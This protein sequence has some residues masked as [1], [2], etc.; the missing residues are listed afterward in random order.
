MQDS[1]VV[2]KR[3]YLVKQSTG[4]DSIS[5]ALEKAE[6]DTIQFLLQKLNVKPLNYPIEAEIRFL[7]KEKLELILSIDLILSPLSPV[8]SRKSEIIEKIVDTFFN[9]FEKALSYVKHYEKK[10]IK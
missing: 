9:S 1:P 2:F 6:E 5:R 3:I 10:H 4:F 7:S 8:V